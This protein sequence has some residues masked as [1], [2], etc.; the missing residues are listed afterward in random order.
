MIPASR[1]VWNGKSEARYIIIVEDADFDF[2][3]NYIEE[4][5]PNA[6]ITG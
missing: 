6:K 3:R 5:C 4:H 1:P 2:V